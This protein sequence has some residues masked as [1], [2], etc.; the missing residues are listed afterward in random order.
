M[1]DYGCSE[2]QYILLF[3]SKHHNC[4][5][6]TGAGRLRQSY[7]HAGS[8]CQGY[9]FS[10]GGNG[11]AMRRQVSTS[12]CGI[13]GTGASSHIIFDLPMFIGEGQRS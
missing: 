8:S 6:V 2:K 10:S 9:H 7:K 1:A 3:F 5:K 12:L 13:L 4:L 11:L